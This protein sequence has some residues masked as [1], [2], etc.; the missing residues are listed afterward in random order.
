ML[1]TQ[2]IIPNDQ[3]KLFPLTQHNSFFRNFPPST[4]MC[5]CGMLQLNLSVILILCERYII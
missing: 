2:M 5:M 3:A 4:Y 1:S